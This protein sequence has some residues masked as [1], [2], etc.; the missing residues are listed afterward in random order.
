MSSSDISADWAN[1]SGPPAAAG[2]RWSKLAEELLE[3]AARV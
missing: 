2:G 1:S 3:L